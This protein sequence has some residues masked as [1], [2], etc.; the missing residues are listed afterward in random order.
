MVIPFTKMQAYGNDYV[1]INAMKVHVADWQNLAIKV[2]N[3]N[4]GVGS[5]GM[6]LICDS[7]VCDFRMRVF[8]PDGTECEMC[9]NALRSV[10]KYVYYYK[11]TDKTEFTVETIGGHQHVSLDVKDGEVI[12]IHADI[13]KPVFETQKIV[14]D[15]D[16]VSEMINIT[17][18]SRSGEPG[19]SE[20]G[21]GEPGSGEPGSSEPGS[22]EPGSSEPGSSK[23]ASGKLN[24]NE[25][26]NVPIRIEDR[27]FYMSSLSWGNPHTVMFIDDVDTLDI[28]KYGPKIENHEIFTNR[29]N[30]TFAQV[31]DENNIKIREWE[32][33]TGETI[34][35]GTGCCTAVVFGNRLRLTGRHV[36]VMQIGGMLHVDWDENDHVHMVGPS[37]VVYEGEYYYEA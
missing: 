14:V 31:I 27:V 16:K 25:F 10:S 20:P 13:G 6:I 2:S 3:R 35:C 33:G 21:S 23:L 1:Y 30:V 7:E 12:C 29:T 17:C 26:I 22:S 9:G 36:D 8:D 5:D 34:G 18:D 19:S 32:R 11:L 15:M 24:R 37:T 28:K 4:F